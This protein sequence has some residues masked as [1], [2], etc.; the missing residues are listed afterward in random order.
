MASVSPSSDS[1]RS[2]KKRR[3]VTHRIIFSMGH[4]G[5]SRNSTNDTL[6]ELLSQRLSRP[7][8]AYPGY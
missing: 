6:R 1:D 7:T 3:S 5:V 4:A 8:S 2:I